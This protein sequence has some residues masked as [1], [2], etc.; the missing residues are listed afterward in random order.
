MATHDGLLTDDCSDLRSSDIEGLNDPL[1]SLVGEWIRS[2]NVSGDK[3][4][5]LHL[6]EFAKRKVYLRDG[7]LPSG[8]SSRRASLDPGKDE[9]IREIAKGLRD[10]KSDFVSSFI[11]EWIDL[12]D[13]PA[14]IIHDPNQPHN[15]FSSPS[16]TS[17]RFGEELDR[18]TA[19]ET[20]YLSFSNSELIL[21]SLQ[22]FSC[23]GF[24][25]IHQDGSLALVNRERFSLF[26]RMV[27]KNYR[28]ENPY[29]NF[30]HAH[31]VL[32]V[33]GNLLRS[34]VRDRFNELEEFSILAAAL[35]HDVGHRGLNSDYYIKTRHSLAIQYNDIS[36]LENMHCSLTFDLLRS[37]ESLNFTHTW[38][39]DQWTQ[40]RRIFIQC[41]LAT[42]M[43]VH[44]DLTANLQKLSSLS[45]LALVENKRTIY[46]AIVHAA[47]LANPVMSTKSCYKWAYRVVEE[48]YEQGKLEE[49][50]GFTVAPFMKYPPTDTTEF[51]KLQV[52]FV[53]FIVAPLWRSMATLWPVL[54]DRV[55]QMDK[56][57]TF[58]Q[59][60]R[61]GQ[62]PE[63]NNN[64]ENVPSSD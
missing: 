11:R 29:H 4:P 35:C 40:F 28:S 56:N 5:I 61:D 23:W 55:A 12:S 18:L 1:K 54:Q 6:Y 10:S 2:A 13:D 36:V 43:K 64:N 49:R 24:H 9:V 41:V 17:S 20:E 38:T 44:F 51:A 25:D 3:D 8:G 32:A 53:E 22:I 19:W 39:E 7:F 48:M 52:S 59:S 31:S 30:H 33:T 62:K 14:G 21:R 50:D 46:Q 15:L 57:V 45:D 42:D 26:V 27:A 58:W 34:C 63:C 16:I 47:D 60:L 37:N